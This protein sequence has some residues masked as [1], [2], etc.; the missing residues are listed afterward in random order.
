MVKKTKGGFA[1]RELR[2]YT[3]YL[4]EAGALNKI[5]LLITL[6]FFL[7]TFQLTVFQFKVISDGGTT[8]YSSDGQASHRWVFL[9]NVPSWKRDSHFW[10]VES[11]LG[12][13]NSFE[14]AVL[15][16]QWGRKSWKGL[17]PVSRKSAGQIINGPSRKAVFVY[18]PRARFQLFCR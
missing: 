6:N 11:L 9:E 13:E 12:R 14:Q 18:T 10:V 2:N 3:H 16:N 5:S 1:H 4:T 8:Y 7:S 15:G 17:G